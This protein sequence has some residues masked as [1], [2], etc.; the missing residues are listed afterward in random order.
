M[1]IGEIV[2]QLYQYLR[3]NTAAPERSLYDHILVDEYQ[4]LNRAEQAVVDLLR[5]SAELCIVGDDQSLYSF[6]FAHPAGIRTFAFSHPGTTDHEI[7]RC[8]RCPESVVSMA[9]ALS[10]TTETGT[11]ASLRRFQRTAPAKW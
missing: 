7:L 4:D 1:L 10:A 3:D 9:N 5:G 8:R 2:P 6:K 11:S